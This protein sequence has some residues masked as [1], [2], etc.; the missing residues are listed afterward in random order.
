[1]PDTRASTLRDMP[2]SARVA[3]LSAERREEVLFVG[4]PRFH[5]QA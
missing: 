1:M 3:H 5:V 2:R 4:L